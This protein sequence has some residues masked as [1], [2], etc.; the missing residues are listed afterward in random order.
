MQNNDWAA[1][2]DHSVRAVRRECI[3]EDWTDPGYIVDHTPHDLLF[4]RWQ[5]LATQ[6]TPE[7][8]DETE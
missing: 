7:D 5:D 2:A 1:I 8:E 6:Y 4:A 3:R